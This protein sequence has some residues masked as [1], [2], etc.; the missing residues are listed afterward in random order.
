MEE[1]TAADALLCFRYNTSFTTPNTIPKIIRFASRKP[2]TPMRIR[3]Q[4][5]SANCEL[6]VAEAGDGTLCVLC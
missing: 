2:P 6:V 4:T 3:A 5:G 1:P